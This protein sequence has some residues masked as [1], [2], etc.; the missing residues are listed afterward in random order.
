M[1][2]IFET[3]VEN[4]QVTVQTEDGVEE[5]VTK[6]KAV[7]SDASSAV[8]LP[9]DFEYHLEDGIE[10]LVLF[11]TES[12][13]KDRV[14]SMV[15][16]QYPTQHFLWWRNPIARQTIPDIWHVQVLVDL[17]HEKGPR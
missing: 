1:G 9:N 4:V 12:L 7:D 17:R 16:E 5:E 6:L 2:K 10:H 8:L 13:D 14:E 3:E 15:K 11:S